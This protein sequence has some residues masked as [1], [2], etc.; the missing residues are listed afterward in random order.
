MI[1]LDHGASGVVPM[2][3]L[4]TPDREDV[5]ELEPDLALPEREHRIEI[6]GGKSDVDLRFRQPQNKLP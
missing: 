2:L 5:V 4:A 1:D 6:V 3:S